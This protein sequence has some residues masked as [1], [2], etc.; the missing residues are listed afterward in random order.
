MNL[1]TA[2]I[3][4]EL[5]QHRNLEGPTK[6]HTHITSEWANLKEAKVVRAT[7]STQVISETGA[8]TPESTISLHLWS[9]SYGCVLGNFQ[10]TYPLTYDSCCQSCTMQECALDNGGRNV[11][12]RRAQCFWVLVGSLLLPRLAALGSLPILHFRSRFSSGV[13]GKL[14]LYSYVKS[15]VTFTLTCF[16]V[17]PASP[18]LL[19]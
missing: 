19:N 3:T 11:S 17:W 1:D 15:K 12:W 5:I 14:G 8:E 16:F 13:L 18:S 9:F 6:G 7:F 2:R 4:Y 10:A